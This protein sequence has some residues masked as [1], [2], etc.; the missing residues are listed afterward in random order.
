MP[1]RGIAPQDDTRV[2]EM[3][4]IFGLI[5]DQNTTRDG[6]DAFIRLEN[7]KTEQIELKPSTKDT[8]VTA[9]NFGRSHINS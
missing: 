1:R 3:L 8:L 2:H 7:G 4:R 9:R 6:T 5:Q